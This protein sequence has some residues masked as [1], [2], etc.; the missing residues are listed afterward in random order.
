MKSGLDLFVVAVLCAAPAVSK[1]KPQRLGAEQLSRLCEAR[2][3]FVTLGGRDPAPDDYGAEVR[4]LKEGIVVR[5]L[6]DYSRYRKGPVE[7]GV[8][9]YEF[10][11]DGGLVERVFEK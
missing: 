2:S 6:V 8:V 5:F 11:A 7:G 4:T 1:D 3:D 10:A 9:R